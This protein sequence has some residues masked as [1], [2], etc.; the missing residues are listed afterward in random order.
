M[1]YLKFTQ[2]KIFSKKKFTE[3]NLH[4]QKNKFGKNK[5]KITKENLRKFTLKMDV[6]GETER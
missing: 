1:Y 4:T 2:K 5:K 3:N 6:H